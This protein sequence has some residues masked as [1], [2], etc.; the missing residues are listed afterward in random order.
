VAYHC[1]HEEWGSSGFESLLDDDEASLVSVECWWK[2]E[3]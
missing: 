3:G 1:Q 2:A